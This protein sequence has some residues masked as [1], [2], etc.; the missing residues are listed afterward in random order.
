VSINAIL[1]MAIVRWAG[2]R[3]VAVVYVLTEVVLLVGYA[4]LVRSYYVRSGSSLSSPGD[5]QAG[6]V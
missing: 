4:G 3:G 2:I 6:G 1:N 5:D